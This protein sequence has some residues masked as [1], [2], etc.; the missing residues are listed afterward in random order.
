MLAEPKQTAAI[1]NIVNQ[2]RRKTGVRILVTLPKSKLRMSSDHGHFI[3]N[4]LA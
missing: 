3:T 4:Y 1:I 2:R